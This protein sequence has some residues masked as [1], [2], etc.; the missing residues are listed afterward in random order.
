MIAEQVEML[1]YSMSIEKRSLQRTGTNKTLGD[2]GQQRSKVRNL[3]ESFIKHQ[4]TGS[5]FAF[6]EHVP[7]NNNLL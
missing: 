3:I 4:Q 6:I 7:F 5:T 2:R 1:I